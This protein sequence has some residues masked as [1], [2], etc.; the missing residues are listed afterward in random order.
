MIYDKDNNLRKNIMRIF[1]DYIKISA[2][3][4]KWRRHTGNSTTS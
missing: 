2:K 4:K 1:P 3:I